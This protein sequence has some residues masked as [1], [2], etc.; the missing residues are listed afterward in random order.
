[1]LRSSHFFGLAWFIVAMAADGIWCQGAQTY[2]LYQSLDGGT[3]WKEVGHPFKSIR[4]NALHADGD[5]VWA[6]TEKGLFASR[7]AGKTWRDLGQARLGNVKGIA[8]TS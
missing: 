6:G 3:S 2:G 1:M 8:A 5:R 4:V 7:D